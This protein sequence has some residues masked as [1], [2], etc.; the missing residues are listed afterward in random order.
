MIKNFRGLLDDRRRIE[1][2]RNAITELVNPKTSIA[3]IGAAL[4][5]YSFF[6][7]KSGAKSVYAIEKDDIFYIGKEIAKQNNLLDKIT[8][9]HNVSTNTELPERIDYIIMEDYSPIFLYENLEQIITDARTRFLKKNGKF[10]PNNILL[11]MA[12]VQCPTLYNTLNIW[13]N[14]NDFLFDIDWSYT[15]DLI[16][17]QP[18]YIDNHTINPLSSETLVKEIDLSKDSEFTFSYFTKSKIL[19]SGVLHG[20]AG[21]WDCWFTPTQFFSNSPN[22]PSNTWGQIFFPFRYPVS[23]KKGDIVRVHLQSFESKYTHNIN[24]KWGIEHSSSIQEQNTFQGNYYSLKKLKSFNKSSKPAL[25]SNGEMTKLI[26]QQIDRK[27]SWSEIA[28]GLIN[29]YP[30]NFSNIDETYSK[31]SEVTKNLVQ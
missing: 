2:F 6:A 3:E 4:G 27:T 1:A 21:W 29:K 26:L 9:I 23:V 16:F 11:K 12:P 30:N 15:T 13:E 31:I 17:N 20:L 18:H 10:I 22:A 19:K 28:K 14:K 7:V 25:N 8:F 5:T 24:Y